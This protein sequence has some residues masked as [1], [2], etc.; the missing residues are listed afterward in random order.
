MEDILR[1]IKEISIIPF[2][3]KNM[4]A[5]WKGKKSLFLLLKQIIW[6]PFV[7]IKEITI[8][9]FKTKNM[10]VITR[11]EYFVSYEILS[12]WTITVSLSNTHSAE[13]SVSQ[14]SH[15]F[16]LHF[17]S[18]LF[19]IFCFY[20]QKPPS[21]ITAKRRAHSPGRQKPRSFQP[22]GN[23]SFWFDVSNYSSI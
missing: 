22:A 8:S 18:S 13:K 2:K 21:P 4:E 7:K 14:L 23:D 12:S 15:V 5:T 16:L 6:R 10:G 20:P 11:G 3:T 17:L 9:P 19:L 1:G